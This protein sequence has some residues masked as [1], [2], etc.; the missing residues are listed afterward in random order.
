MSDIGH[1][2]W[3]LTLLVHETHFFAP[4]LAFFWLYLG[5]RSWVQKH[6]TF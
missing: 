1:S 6:I 5:V 4:D 2:P 3:W